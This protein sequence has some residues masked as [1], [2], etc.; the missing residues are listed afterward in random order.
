MV[1]LDPLFPNGKRVVSNCLLIVC[2]GHGSLSSDLKGLSALGSCVV[3]QRPLV[4]TEFSCRASC[5][6]GCEQ[7]QLGSADWLTPPFVCNDGM[8]RGHQ[9]LSK[10]L[11]FVLVEGLK[12]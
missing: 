8:T 2:L 9:I 7:S 4:A 11:S 3:L 6:Q 12:I 1:S 10:S 5:F